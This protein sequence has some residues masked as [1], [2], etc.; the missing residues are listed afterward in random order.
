[1]GI[2]TCENKE[3][4]AVMASGA[5]K[6]HACGKKTYFYWKHPQAFLILTCLMIFTPI[7]YL[8]GI[9]INILLSPFRLIEFMIN[10]NEYE[11]EIE[12]NE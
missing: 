7:F 4:N 2:I 1:M 9:I 10:K 8:L 12:E 5:S 6:C 3:C 11:Q